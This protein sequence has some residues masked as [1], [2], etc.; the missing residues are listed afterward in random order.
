MLSKFWAQIWLWKN[1]V[2]CFP[3]TR[4]NKTKE[5]FYFKVLV[6]PT[7]AWQAQLHHYSLAVA[8]YSG[9]PS[10]EVKSVGLTPLPFIQKSN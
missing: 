5:L 6:T 3:K 10:Y 4:S 8:K 7:P 9:A 1:T 2:C